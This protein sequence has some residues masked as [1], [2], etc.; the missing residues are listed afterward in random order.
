MSSA[1]AADKLKELAFETKISTRLKEMEQRFE[2]R[3]QTVE[4]KLSVVLNLPETA[5]QNI[6]QITANSRDVL[7][8]TQQLSTLSKEVFSLVTEVAGLRRQFAQGK[9]SSRSGA[10][11]GNDSF[12]TLRR[13]VEAY[14]SLKNEIKYVT[15]VQEHVA[16]KAGF[17]AVAAASCDGPERQ[18]MYETLRA[19]EESLRMKAPAA[20]S[21]L[22]ALPPKRSSLA[23]DSAWS[24]AE[25]AFHEILLVSLDRTDGSILGV[26]VEHE[27]GRRLKVAQ[28]L[29]GLMQ[30]Y[31]EEFPL[32]K[33][34]EGDV[35]L[36]VNGV[37]SDSHG[38]V[39]EL[40]QKKVMKL[41]VG[42]IARPARL[43]VDET[44]I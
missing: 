8:H 44:A 10:G 14:E 32:K 28:V 4:S 25:D 5:K 43:G 19:K 40:A 20:G 1:H 18:A 42:L 35:I 27:D 17:L 16:V 6:N 21:E 2:Q 3:L 33:V 26:K 30:D 36:E 39:D 13:H 24:E 41:R 37:E 23:S 15:E 12:V 29:P 38:M 34:S 7:A 31:N 22:A 11:E 9:G